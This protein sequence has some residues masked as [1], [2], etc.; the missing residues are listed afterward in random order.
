VEA[1]LLAHP[2]VAEAGVT[3]LDDPQWGAVPVA[4]VVLRPGVAVTEGELLA[5][6]AGRLARYKVPVAI[7]FRTELPR[8]A[9]GKLQRRRL[10]NPG[11]TS[12]P[13]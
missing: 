9:S 13:A 4:A 7:A 11:L 8:T 12:P 1:V 10:P 5:F 6:C 2:A 3:G